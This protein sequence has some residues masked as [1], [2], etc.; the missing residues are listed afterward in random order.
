MGTASIKGLC[1]WLASYIARLFSISQY[2]KVMSQL[3][4]VRA[5]QKYSR[6]EMN[7]RK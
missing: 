3:A 2:E 6:D 1:D 4:H 7:V 5:G